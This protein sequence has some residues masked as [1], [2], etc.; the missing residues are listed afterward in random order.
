VDSFAMMQRVLSE[1]QRVVD[2]IEPTQL[3]NPTPCAD[4]SVRDVLNHITGGGEMFAIAGRDGSV[5]DD[6]VVQLMTGDNIGDDYK[7]AFEASA[8]HATEAF[9]A[10]GALDRIVTLPFGEMPARAALDIAVFDLTTHAWD[11]ARATGQS[12]SLDPEVLGT[13]LEIAQGMLSDD[14][15]AMGMFGP[16]VEVPDD[17]PVQDRLAAFTGRTP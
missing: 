12:T 3:D 7:Q 5:P 8:A 4:W 1:T 13:A 16:V 6:K 11:L 10:P 17:A 2:G 9:E 14:Y 15:R